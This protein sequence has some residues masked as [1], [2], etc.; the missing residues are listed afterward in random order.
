MRVLILGATGFAGRHLADELARQGHEV[1]GAARRVS[2]DARLAGGG[3][4]LRC[5]V[6]RREE[7]DAVL[8]ESA[9]AAVVLLAG[10][11]SPPAAQADPEAAYRVHALGA[12]HLLAAAAARRPAPRVL[13][14]TSSEVYG[15]VGPADL[16]LT[17]EAPLRPTTIYA[18][19][20]AAADLAARAFARSLDLDVVRVRAFNHTG[21]G[22]RRDFVCADFAAQVA[23]ISA[24][25]RPPLMEVGNLDAERDFTDVR[26]IVRGYA[27]ALLRGR[28]GEVYNLC[29]GRPTRIG[30]I[31]EDLCA[32]AG[33]RPE[34]R[35]AAERRRRA[36]VPA[37][38]G[39]AA[40]AEAE[41]GWR[42]EIPW[43]RTLSDL[44]RDQ[45]AE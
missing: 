1:V 32:L 6:T 16:P 9:A 5:D 3:H 40:K 27:A 22:Q 11:S 42:P 45:T 39:S 41:L 33:V 23:A 4:L 18:A 15:E 14:V 38:W 12:V 37:Y 29:S 7:V 28:P 21:P 36:E 13:L 24:G 35:V 30:A 44:L 10:L 8:A 2:A 31:L 17:E 34:V 19:S 25:R 26:D 43:R 20:K